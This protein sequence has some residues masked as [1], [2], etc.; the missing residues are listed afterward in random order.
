MTIIRKITAA[1]AL[2]ALAGSG[3]AAAADA[4]IVSRQHTSTARTAPTTIPGTG[5]QKGE[6][7][8][9]GARLVYRTVTLEGRQTAKLT[10]RAPA[11]KRIRAL[12]PQEGSDVGFVVTTKGSYVGRTAVTLR[13]YK[14]P[15]AG[16]EVSGRIYGLAR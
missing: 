11:G 15:K 13:A 6:K 5:I 12:V 7:L 3:V 1:T 8:P 4:P 2:V 16:G 9:S 10:L 14:N